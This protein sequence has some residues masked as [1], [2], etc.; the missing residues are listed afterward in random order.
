MA[1]NETGLGLCS[2]GSHCR[3]EILGPHGQSYV[4]VVRLGHLVRCQTRALG[5]QNTNK[6][7]YACVYIR[8]PELVAPRTGMPDLPTQWHQLAIIPTREGAHE[9]VRPVGSATLTAFTSS[10]DVLRSTMYSL[11]IRRRGRRSSPFEGPGP[12]WATLPSQH[13][14]IP[15]E[16]RAGKRSASRH[17]LG[18]SVLGASEEEIGMH[19]VVVAHQTRKFLVASNSIMRDNPRTGET[20]QGRAK[21]RYNAGIA[22]QK[23]PTA[24]SGVDRGVDGCRPNG[25]KKGRS[26]GRSG[27]ERSPSLSRS[28]S[29]PAQSNRWTACDDS[30]CAR[31][32]HDG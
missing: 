13:A 23:V 7:V 8:P 9:A 17:R 20:K 6:T 11:D 19:F 22:Q 24:T 29:V 32:Q 1:D 25:R 15:P 12:R 26:L 28:V 10:G 5:F 21:R 30:W 27:P 4:S 14:G 16:S 31:I 3:G 2:S 18:A